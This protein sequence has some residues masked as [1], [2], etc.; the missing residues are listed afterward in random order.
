[1][2]VPFRPQ[3][4]FCRL[5][6]DDVAQTV[7]AYIHAC[8]RGKLALEFRIRRMGGG[9]VRVR[10]NCLLDMRGAWVG[11]IDCLGKADVAGD[12]IFVRHGSN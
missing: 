2:G 3:D 8:A 7:R 6:P 10:A 9:Y 5:H 4:F 1:V 12:L 11:T